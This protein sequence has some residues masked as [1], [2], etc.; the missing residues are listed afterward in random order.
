MAQPVRRT[1]PREN[2]PRLNRTNEQQRLL[3]QCYMSL[4]ACLHASGMSTPCL[5]CLGASLSGFVLSLLLCCCW[6]GFFVLLFVLLF[7]FTHLRPSAFLDFVLTFLL[8]HLFAGVF[9]CWLHLLASLFAGCL[10]DFQF[11]FMS[12]IPQG[13]VCGLSLLLRSSALPRSLTMCI[14]TPPS[15]ALPCPLSRFSSS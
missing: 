9:A 6:W 3:L 8:A 5:A 7:L 4:F 11:L 14:N 15:P 2:K 10:R 13:L 1:G 12:A